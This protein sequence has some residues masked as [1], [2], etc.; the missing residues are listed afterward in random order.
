MVRTVTTK[1]HSD[2]LAQV[3]SGS[4]LR[5]HR[6]PSMYDSAFIGWSCTQATRYI[7]SPVYD[8]DKMYA[9]D[10]RE[11]AHMTIEAY[12]SDMIWPTYIQ[13][14]TKKTFPVLFIASQTIEDR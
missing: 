2:L 1:T 3:V 4:D 5:A 10:G 7:S 6:L 8:L 13:S 11:V 14:D 9:I 12:Y